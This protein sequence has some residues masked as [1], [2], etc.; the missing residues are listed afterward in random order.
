MG[1]WANRC[2]TLRVQ[3]C[4]SILASHTVAGT[5]CDDLMRVVELEG[6]GHGPGGQATGLGYGG[7]LRG[8]VG[9][10][11]GCGSESAEDGSLHRGWPASVGP[12]AG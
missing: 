9:G 10:D 8:A 11:L 4:A 1:L 3:W 12:V 7:W 2:R 5:L 6:V